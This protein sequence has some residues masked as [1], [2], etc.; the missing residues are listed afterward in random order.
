MSRPNSSYL[1]FYM[2]GINPDKVYKVNGGN[3]ALDGDEL[4]NAGY[5]VNQV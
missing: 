3:E 2:K 4:M 1:R 5:F